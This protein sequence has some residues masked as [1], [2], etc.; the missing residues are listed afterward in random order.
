[1]TRTS[2]ERTTARVT[3]PRKTD[4]VYTGNVTRLPPVDPDTIR[5]KLPAHLTE[6][7]KKQN[8]EAITKRHM[9]DNDDD[10]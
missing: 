8:R 2:T 9:G 10:R 6:Q 3:V 7:T 4:W 1:M 5:G